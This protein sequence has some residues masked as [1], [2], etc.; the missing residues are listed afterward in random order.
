[1]CICGYILIK[2]LIQLPE[3][4]FTFT[5]TGR[6]KKSQNQ[7]KRR[8]ESDEVEPDAKKRTG[9][10][11]G[12]QVSRKVKTDESKSDVPRST[13][14]EKSDTKLGDQTISSNDASFAIEENVAPGDDP[15]TVEKSK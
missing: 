9:T 7:K 2:F 15:D 4:I 14:S 13:S 1:M 11:Q 12:P 10:V 8:R 3:G 6:P 5:A